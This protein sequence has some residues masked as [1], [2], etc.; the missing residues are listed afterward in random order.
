M[1][2]LVTAA[3]EKTRDMIRVHTRMMRM[4][5]L[6][7][8]F[9]W[10]A[11]ILALPAFAASPWTEPS[12]TL[13]ERVADKVGA[14]SAITFTLRNV[15]SLGASE[16]AG[17]REEILKQLQARGMTVVP[18]SRAE[19]EVAITLSENAAGYLWIG[20]TR[21]A[22]S[23]P[24]VVM[25]RVPRNQPAVTAYSGPSVVLRKKLL[26]SQPDG[27]Q[28]LDAAP[29]NVVAGPGVLLLTPSR[30]ALYVLYSGKWQDEFSLPLPASRAAPVSRDPRGRI[31][32]GRGFSVYLPGRRCSSVNQPQLRMDC[33]ESDDPWPLGS[34]E[35][36][37]A[38]YAPA[39]NFFNGTLAGPL[40]GGKTVSPFFSAARVQENGTELWLLAGI[41]GRIRFF[42]G[43]N[44]TA[45]SFGNWGSDI[46]SV[47]T[48]CGAGWQVLATRPG[49]SAETDAAQAFEIVGRQAIAVSDPVDFPGP[50]TALWSRDNEATAVA[51]NVKTG[52]YEAYSLSLDC[53][54]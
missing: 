2:A 26:W 18:E 23:S 32:V 8:V 33:V 17:V 13:A 20:E 35:T 22:H 6:I 34:G 29:F 43:V 31:T 7:P 41:D 15:S 45:A 39:R 19:A 36:L 10:L 28:I 54:H 52:R 46:T 9:G 16:V 47:K 53:G 37:Q 5:R 4:P 30:F 3:D 12:A 14:G 24:G 40:A 25:V 51:R 49:G 21:L 11:M 1:P 38:F 48:G 42:N 50:V 44:D 27:E